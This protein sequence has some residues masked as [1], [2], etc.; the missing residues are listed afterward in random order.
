[1]PNFCFCLGPAPAEPPSSQARSCPRR[2]QS[3]S[4][5]KSAVS[6][7]LSLNCNVSTSSKETRILKRK[8]SNHEI[9]LIHEKNWGKSRIQVLTKSRDLTSLSFAF[10]F[11]S[12]ISRISWLNSPAFVLVSASPRCVL[13]VP[14]QHFS[15]S[16][17]Q[18]FPS[19]L[20]LWA[21]REF[22]RSVYHFHP[23]IQKFKCVI[24]RLIPAPRMPVFPGQNAP[25]GL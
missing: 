16:V 24:R 8:I 6:P 14:F 2:P 20:P 12:C 11:L 10:A 15:I 18:L 7:R 4:S 5:V 21:G 9:H 19:Y 1:M 22:S 25:A 3:V 17:F 13:C 23:L